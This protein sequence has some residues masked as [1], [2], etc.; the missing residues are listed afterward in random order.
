MTIKELYKTNFEDAV[1]TLCY[2]SDYYITSIEIIKDFIKKLLDEDN[3]IFAEHLIVALNN[4]DAYYY[5]Y[6]FSLGTF[7]TPKPLTELE[8]LE[9][10]SSHT[11][12]VQYT[13]Q[14]AAYP[15]QSSHR[16][17]WLRPGISRHARPDRASPPS[18]APTNYPPVSA[19][20]PDTLHSS[21]LAH[22]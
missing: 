1:T 8:D 7:E 22:I 9:V 11:H 2:E 3:F 6:D 5:D 12:S 17:P 16:H 13:L 14:V 15:R 4:T 10:Q 19:L 20:L 18:P 21:A